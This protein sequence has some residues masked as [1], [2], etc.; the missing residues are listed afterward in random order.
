MTLLTTQTLVF[1]ASEIVTP[2][3][4]GGQR[5]GKGC[6]IGAGETYSNIRKSCVRVFD[7]GIRLNAIVKQK[8]AVFSAFIVFASEEGEGNVEVFLPS[9]KTSFMMRQIKGENAGL[10][11]SKSLSLNYW[12]GMYSLDNARG[13]TI[14]QGPNE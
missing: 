11:K 10:W 2:P 13:K 14:Y 4:I 6:L 8:N 3:S 9:R 7:V 12:K 1:S 5:D